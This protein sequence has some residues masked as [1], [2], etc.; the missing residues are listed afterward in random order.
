[1]GRYL[2]ETGRPIVYS[3]SWPAYE[4]PL[5]IQVCSILF[6]TDSILFYFSLVKLYSF[7]RGM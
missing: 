6:N 7:S 2:N 4:E 1:M 5:G 3:C